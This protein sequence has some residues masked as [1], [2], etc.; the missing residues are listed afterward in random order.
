MEIEELERRERD[1]RCSLIRCLSCDK[2]DGRKMCI[3]AK[4][5]KNPPQG[6]HEECSNATVSASKPQYMRVMCDCRRIVVVSWV[7]VWVLRCR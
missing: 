4:A 2:Q 7:W 3:A 5:N 1:I 6:I